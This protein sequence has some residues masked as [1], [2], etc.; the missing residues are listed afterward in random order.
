MHYIRTAVV[1]VKIRIACDLSLI[2]RGNKN[3]AKNQPPKT[4]RIQAPAISTDFSGT[5]EKTG[6]LRENQSQFKR[7][8]LSPLYSCST[9]C[10][11]NP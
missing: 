2:W 9:C 10:L 11:R 4:L 3:K 8:E 1:T 7:E 6:Y 5:C